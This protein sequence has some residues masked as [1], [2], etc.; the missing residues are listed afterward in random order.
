MAL[1][2]RSVD[3]VESMLSQSQPEKEQKPPLLAE[4]AFLEEE[5]AAANQI[6]APHRQD[7]PTKRVHVRTIGTSSIVTG[8]LGL[9]KPHVQPEP[10]PET[11]QSDVIE[12]VAPVSLNTTGKP[13]LMTVPLK[14]GPQLLGDVPIRIAAD[15]TVLI[16]KASLSHR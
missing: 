4:L 1:D 7:R 9:P 8:A 2:W 6:A 15:G 3:V 11:Q 10:Q 5:P 16:S 12:D 14:D 13:I